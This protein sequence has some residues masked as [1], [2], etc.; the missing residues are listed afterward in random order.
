MTGKIDRRHGRIADFVGH[1]CHLLNKNGL[2]KE[3]R[4]CILSLTK[5][6][7]GSIYDDDNDKT[8]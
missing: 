5:E 2:T 1:N 4:W 3:K 6:K 7:R 8:K